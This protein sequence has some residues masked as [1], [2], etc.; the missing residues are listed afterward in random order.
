VKNVNNYAFI[1]S[2]NLNL[3]IHSLGWDIDYRK[4]RLYLKNKFDVSNA[5]MFIGYVPANQRLYTQLQKA[6]FI[7]VYKTAISYMK[8]GKTFIKGNVDAELVL[9]SAAIEYPNYDQAVIVTNDGDFFCLVQYLDDNRKLL[10][11]LAPNSRYSSL[12]R[13][14]VDKLQTLDRLENTL[15]Y[16]TGIGVRSKP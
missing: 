2:Q 5:F 4:F 6:G 13:P 9:H 11:I 1:D 16:K 14:Y 10:K 3:G 12:F 8:N 7:L 15:K